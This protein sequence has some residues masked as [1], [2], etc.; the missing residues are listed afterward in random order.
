VFPEVNNNSRL[1]QRGGA[2][3]L[4]EE[5]GVQSWSVWFRRLACLP[6]NS[7]YLVITWAVSSDE[8]F[9]VS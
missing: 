6:P 7:T 9:D 4:I 5:R 3:L 1:V 8:G 2:I